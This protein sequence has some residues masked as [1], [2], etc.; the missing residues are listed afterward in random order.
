MKRSKLGYQNLKFWPS[1]QILK[2]SRVRN[3]KLLK[4]T[5]INIANE[6]KE[7]GSKCEAKQTWISELDQNLK[8]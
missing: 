6:I 1:D 3:V 5:R 8:L 4:K 7:I 2:G